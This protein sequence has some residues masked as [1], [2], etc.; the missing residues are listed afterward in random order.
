MSII[1]N[2]LKKIQNE[3]SQNRNKEKSR[4]PLPAA[5]HPLSQPP[6]ETPVMNGGKHPSL[7]QSLIVA[8]IAIVGVVSA[9]SGFT[10]LSQ[11]RLRNKPV[12]RKSAPVPP[13]V[14]A[15]SS[16][17]TQ[18]PSAIVSSLPANTTVF[19]SSADNATLN[20]APPPPPP[21]PPFPELKL[22]GIMY[23]AD[24]KVVI[25]NNNIV[26]EGDSLEGVKILEIHQD[27]VVLEFDGRRKLLKYYK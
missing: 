18:G 27:G 14:A 11:G 21:P 10:M 5:G 17:L 3:I 15:Q 23:S 13:L 6:Q 16:N 2:A 22:N 12:E 7:K 1:Y 25:I 19:S 9:I 4:A 24:E 20:S 26:H 8:V